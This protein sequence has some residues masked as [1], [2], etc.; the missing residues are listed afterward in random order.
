MAGVGY[1]V[2]GRNI[3]SEVEEAN[4]KGV[5]WVSGRDLIVDLGTMRPLD[6]GRVQAA[7]EGQV[8]LARR[9]G[10]NTFVAGARKFGHLILSDEFIARVLSVPKKQRTPGGSIS[11][12]SR[13]GDGGARDS[14]SADSGTMHGRVSALVGQG[15]G[16]SGRNLGR[17]GHTHL[18]FR[19]GSGRS[20]RSSSGVSVPGGC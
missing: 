5:L 15:R 18:G 2:D 9:R 16:Q 11:D 10:K 3:F 6:H 13:A 17:R 4:A 12:K 7:V 8:K 1:R 14:R 20:G 19:G